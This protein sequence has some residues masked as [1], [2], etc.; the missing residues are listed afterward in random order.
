MTILTKSLAILC[1]ILAIACAV[2]WGMNASNAQRIADMQHAAELSAV[3]IESMEQVQRIQDALLA[4]RAT[5]R[6]AL[7]A[8]IDSLSK[9][10]PHGKPRPRPTTVPAIRDS[11]LRATRTR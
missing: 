8:D 9:L 6:E 1:G 5:E 2:L 10:I 7:Q 3:R 4:Q 11:I